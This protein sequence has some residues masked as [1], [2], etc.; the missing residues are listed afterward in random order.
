M[1]KILICN[2]LILV[3]VG[4]A[5]AINTNPTATSILKEHSQVDILQYN[6][7]IYINATSLES[8]KKLEFTK[9]EKIGE[10]VKTTNSSKKFKDFYATKLESGTEIF[11]T[12]DNNTYT[13]IAESNGQQILY[14]VLLEG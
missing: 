5:P 12:N 9:S 7:L 1:R 8:I 11:S 13:I 3:L 6:N 14:T 10:V 2:L 4:C